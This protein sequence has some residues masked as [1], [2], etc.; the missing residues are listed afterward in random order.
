MT[1]KTKSTAIGLSRESATKNI[2]G[3]DEFKYG[4]NKAT[5]LLDVRIDHKL[6]VNVKYEIYTQLTTAKNLVA[7]NRKTFVPPESQRAMPHLN[8]KDGAK[9]MAGV[10]EGNATFGQVIHCETAPR[11]PEECDDLDYTK[12][13]MDYWEDLNSEWERCS[14]DGRNRSYT[15]DRFMSNEYYIELK[16]RKGVKQ[17]YNKPED[18]LKEGERNLDAGD[19]A[20]IDNAIVDIL[21]YRFISRKQRAELF[22]SHN[23]GKSLSNQQVLNVLPYAIANHV[24]NFA[25]NS[26]EHT[27]DGL[28][29]AKIKK[30]TKAERDQGIDPR[31]YKCLVTTGEWVSRN[32]EIVTH[33]MFL[34]DLKT[35][36]LSLNKGNVRAFWDSY[37]TNKNFDNYN[38]HE[39][40]ETLNLSNSV[41]DLYN[42]TSASTISTLVK[43]FVL[44]R[45]MVINSGASYTTDTWLD[46]IVPTFCKLRKGIMDENGPIEDYPEHFYKI[47]GRNVNEAYSGIVS[48]QPG[49]QGTHDKRI[50]V[51][52]NRVVN[53]ILNDEDIPKIVERSNL[54]SRPEV[55]IQVARDNGY[56]T[57]LGEPISD[58]L[59][60]QYHLDHK[61]SLNNYGEDGIANLG[62]L[63]AGDN[64]SKGSKNLDEWLEERD[65]DDQ[66]TL[67][68][69]DTNSLDDL[70]QSELNF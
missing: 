24:R 11:M 43:D 25:I 35:K 42:V 33:L 49:H 2:V 56:K 67:D 50:E 46:L 52:R 41:I 13:D 62:F 68:L 19:K 30:L 61:T 37:E 7:I 18:E 70:D 63:H 4:A 5:D 23:N 58:P 26:V 27:V 17:W 12:D 3:Q 66:Y 40:Y 38:V 10:I 44:F 9:F 65:D 53:V 64:L 21:V 39:F 15:C 36:F 20:A 51:L 29:V 34:H 69:D 16:S 8:D 22:L 54:T 28:G 55:R 59:D 32:E 47:K 1:N 60:G 14:I 57:A 48:N 6:P 45:K 31:V